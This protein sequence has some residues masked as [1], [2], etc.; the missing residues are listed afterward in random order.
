MCFRSVRA[1]RTPV[2]GTHRPAAESAGTTPGIRL[3]AAL[4]WDGWLTDASY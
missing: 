2:K 1:V 3:P 4:K